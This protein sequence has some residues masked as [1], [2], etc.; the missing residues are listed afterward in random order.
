MFEDWFFQI[1]VPASRRNNGKKV[2][3]R[4]NLGS[5][6]FYKVIEA[7]EENNISFPFLP[8]N[9][10]HLCQ[11]LDVT[12]LR[13][14]KISWRK[15]LT[16]WKLHNKGVIP[17][18]VFPS[19]LK[20]MLANCSEKISANILSGFEATGISPYNLEK[21]LTK[22]R[23][24]NDGANQ[25]NPA[26]VESFSNIMTELTRVN[27]QPAITRKKKMYVP[28]G[29]SISSADLE[30]EADVIP[31]TSTSIH[32]DD[33]QDDSD[34]SSRSSVVDETEDDILTPVE[35]ASD[36]HESDFAMTSFIY[37]A[38]MKKKTKDFLLHK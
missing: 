23:L 21:V 16:D 35:T 31:T 22:M 11:P 15:V 8:K 24:R 29:K 1:A 36:I 9:S 34:H 20:K 17:K 27:E 10:T 12:I 2:I 33:P 6:L 3:I 32:I 5:H 30:D 4:D 7:C 13:P 18:L 26:T 25:N 37:N 19:L 38:G 28:S 14:I